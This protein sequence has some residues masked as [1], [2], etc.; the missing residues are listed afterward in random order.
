MICGYS[1]NLSKD[2]L[3]V[4]TGLEKELGKT[5]MALSCRDMMPAELSKEQLAKITD[6]E[7]KLGV[8]LVALNS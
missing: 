1:E 7:K 8:V 5:I 3:N 2:D 6:A 4:L